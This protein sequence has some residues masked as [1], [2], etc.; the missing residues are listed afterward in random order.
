MDERRRN[1]NERE[2]SRYGRDDRDDD[3]GQAGYRSDT[4]PRS[5]ST[6]GEYE[7]SYAERRGAAGRAFGERDT[8]SGYSPPTYGW[9][10]AYR[11]SRSYDAYGEPRQGFADDERDYAPMD[12][13]GVDYGPPEAHDY[14]RAGYTG[15][16][17]PGPRRARSDD[18]E[19]G[20]EGRR[21]FLDRAADHVASWFG[22][23]HDGEHHEARTHRGRGP[24]GY[25]RSDERIAEDV[26]D[27]LTD[28]PWLDA[29]EVVV[30]VTAREVLLSGAVA[31]RDAKHRAER[32][33]EQV[34]GVEHVQNNLR[35]GHVPGTAPFESGNPLTTPGR[36][37]GDSAL[38]AQT[39]GETRSGEAGGDKD[40]GKSAGRL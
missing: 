10:P 2:R 27:Q 26:N 3:Y 23:G 20:D 4:E 33:A 14:Y 21:G 7:R 15:G 29:T 40:K 13:G 11:R 36:G 31:D 35:I 6:R 25:R 30:T 8:G 37:Y 16:Y 17:S 32:L 24:K 19:R 12:M 22:G 18:V 1:W 34:S 28:D 9:E 5:F 39:N 38:E